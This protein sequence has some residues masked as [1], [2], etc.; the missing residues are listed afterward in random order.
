[1]PAR[2]RALCRPASSA[3]NRLPALEAIDSEGPAAC[4]AAWRDARRASR[5][6]R[7]PGR[8]IVGLPGA[9]SRLLPARPS[10]RDA[11]EKDFVF[12]KT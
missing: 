8:E 7:A 10:R 6:P 3:I 11:F 5:A 12:A 9:L 2:T 4:T 1:M